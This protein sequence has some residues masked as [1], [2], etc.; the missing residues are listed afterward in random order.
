MALQRGTIFINAI[1]LS[2]NN[3]SIDGAITGKYMFKKGDCRQGFEFSPMMGIITA[4][5]L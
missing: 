4:K 5:L 3:G 1:T 2:N